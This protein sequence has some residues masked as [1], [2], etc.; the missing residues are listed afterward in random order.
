MKIKV[1]FFVLAIVF[2]SNI[3][4]QINTENLRLDFLSTSSYSLSFSENQPPF[5]SLSIGL[6]LW[7]FSFNIKNPILWLLFSST[8]ISINYQYSFIE[9]NNYLIFGYSILPL[10]MGI[11]YSFMF[12]M[13]IIGINGAYNFNK[14]VFSVIPEISIHWLI[15][16]ELTY[17]YNIIIDNDYNNKH[18]FSIKFKLPLTLLEKR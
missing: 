4:S 12:P 2:I 9:N 13:P 14:N 1:L 5:S 3:H 10:L 17:K 15:F 16:F 8:E 11:E 7:I 6:D 18:E